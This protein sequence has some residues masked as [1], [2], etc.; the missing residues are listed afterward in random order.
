MIRQYFLREASG[1]VLVVRR[2]I[3]RNT[4]ARPRIR[5]EV[6][7]HAIL[8]VRDDGVGG[9]QNVRRR[10]VV[11][12]QLHNVFHAVIR[13]E[14]RHVADARA[15]ESVNRLI[16]VAHA[17]DGVRRRFRRSNRLNPPKLQRVRI[18]EFV[19]Q[20]KSKA[21][22]IVFAQDGVSFQ[23]FRTAQKQF[24]KVHQTVLLTAR[25]IKT[26][27]TGVAAFFV[28]GDVRRPQPRFLKAVDARLK[29]LRIVHVGV[30]SR[31]LHEALNE[32]QLI[33]RIHDLES[34]GEP[35]FFGVIAQEAV[36]DPVKRPHPHRADVCRHHGFQ[37]ILHF[38]GGLVRKR[39]R[40]NL[41]GARHALRQNPGNAGRQHPRF[42]GAG[43]RQ[44]QGMFRGQF[45]RRALHG[46]QTLHQTHQILHIGH[47]LH[48]RNTRKG[49]KMLPSFP[50][51]STRPHDFSLKKALSERGILFRSSI[52][53]PF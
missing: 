1:F 38:F 45:H 27:K 15:A 7:A 10:T 2:F 28:R 16:V 32:G 20:N 49:R 17:E 46:V 39:H 42:A 13:D 37:A 50:R 5:P 24:R 26:V 11:L 21:C 18:L 25:F 22:S 43:A 29:G 14:I 4:V 47:R 33:R 6:L 12:F 44:N 3:N 19:H 51:L 40:E 31:F 41:R 34:L 36:C 30:N 35:R 53:R 8:V 48:K 23:Q 52:P 9:I